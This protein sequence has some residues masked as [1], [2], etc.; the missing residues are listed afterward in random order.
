MDEKFKKLTRVDLGYT[1][2]K[3]ISFLNDIKDQITY[4]N[5][6]GT[7]VPA[8]Q[9]YQLIDQKEIM[10]EKGTKIELPSNITRFLT[11]EDKIK[12]DDETV[13]TFKEESVP[14][15]EEGTAWVIKAEGESGQ[16]TN[17]VIQNGNDKKIIPIRIV[18]KAKDA[19]GFAQKDMTIKQ[20]S[21]MKVPI[22]NLKNVDEYYIITESNDNDDEENPDDIL[23]T[24]W[25]YN[26]DEKYKY[27]EP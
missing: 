9:R 18:D 10:V 6:S 25:G 3:D 21:F 7:K 11:E 5:V 24:K 14:S 22:N 23:D 8:D 12:V 4:L 1:G 27:F 2:V 26:E 16:A 15:I 17:L 20:H 13:A 19:I